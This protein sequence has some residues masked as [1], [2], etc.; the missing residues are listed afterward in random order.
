MREIEVDWKKY[1]DTL[2]KYYEDLSKYQ[3][4]QKSKEE[5]EAM[6]LWESI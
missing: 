5:A 4:L 2:M 6:S 1:I 3:S